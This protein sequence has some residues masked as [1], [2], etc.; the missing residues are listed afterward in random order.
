MGHPDK[1]PPL[2]CN[3]LTDNRHTVNIFYEESLELTICLPPKAGTTNWQNALAAIHEQHGRG[4]IPRLE[5]SSYTDPSGVINKTKL[6]VMNARNP[7]QVKNF[8]CFFRKLQYFKRLLSAWRDKFSKNASPKRQNAYLPAIKVFEHKYS[9]PQ[10]FVSSF[11]AFIEY[12]A[13]NPNEYSQ[14]LTNI[15]TF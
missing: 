6:F 8:L 11:E 15:Y 5:K 3:P 7:F 12:L 4:L 14:D 2:A 13:A 1:K 10:G 9:V